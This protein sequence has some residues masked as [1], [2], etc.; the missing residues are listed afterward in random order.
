MVIYLELLQLSQALLKNK[1]FA[2]FDDVSFLG[3]L[4]PLFSV[5]EKLLPVSGLGV[6]FS[7]IVILRFSY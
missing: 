4:C 5:D 1:M 7:W 3:M 6:E 2:E